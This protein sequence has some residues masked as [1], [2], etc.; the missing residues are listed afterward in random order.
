MFWRNREAAVTEPWQYA[1]R[2][3][4]PEI[5]ELFDDPYDKED[6]IEVRQGHE[7]VSAGD[8]LVSSKFAEC[9]AQILINQVDG[10][11]LFKHVGPTHLDVF[12]GSDTGLYSGVVY[13]DFLDNAA[14]TNATVLAVNIRGSLGKHTL[15][16]SQAH[17]DVR[18]TQLPE[19]TLDTGD[20][21]TWSVALN[22]T[23]SELFIKRRDGD[24]QVYDKFQLPSVYPEDQAPSREALVARIER[25]RLMQRSLDHLGR[26]A[27]SSPEYRRLDETHTNI[28][29][30]GLLHEITESRVSRLGME[31]T[32]SF[33]KKA[34]YAET[35]DDFHPGLRALDMLVDLTALVRDN[36]HPEFT[37]VHAMS[38]RILDVMLELDG[39]EDAP[40]RARAKDALLSH[41]D[42]HIAALPP[43][44]PGS[45]EEL[46]VEGTRQIRDMIDD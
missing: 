44:A 26:V 20:Q 38:Y 40:A 36:G 27:L 14:Q 23:T 30:S 43:T 21:H 1:G 32:D 11:T 25:R 33:S 5:Q 28:F 13:Q 37:R 35:P 8:W 45:T 16:K 12:N 41:L 22:P 2:V 34:H 18:I 6:F 46:I 42:A 17:P 39:N 15:A 24:Q 3:E 29:D 4:G 10:S 19:I 7:E 31:W 9:S